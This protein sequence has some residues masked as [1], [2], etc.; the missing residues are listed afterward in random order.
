MNQEPQEGMIPKGLGKYL[1]LAAVG[2]MVA[3]AIVNTR[4]QTE[5]PQ[6]QTKS[7]AELKRKSR[8][9]EVTERGRQNYERKQSLTE[10]GM[11][12]V[13]LSGC[14]YLPANLGVQYAGDWLCDRTGGGPETA[15]W[16]VLA[17]R[18]LRQ[19]DETMLYGSAEFTCPAEVFAHEGIRRRCTAGGHAFLL[20]PVY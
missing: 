7:P 11:V 2:V 8:A 3:I 10:K 16:T 6:K 1:A 14:A 12:T 5:S 15:R 4:N 18:P 9:E 13:R 19:A 17:V 20:A